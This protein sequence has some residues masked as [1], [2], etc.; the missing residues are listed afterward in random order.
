MRRCPNHRY[1]LGYD[2]NG[3]WCLDGALGTLPR[4]RR[5]RLPE[6]AIIR[7]FG[8]R[9]LVSDPN[10]RRPTFPG[11]RR[12]GS[13]CGRCAGAGVWHRRWGRSAPVGEAF[14]RAMRPW[15]LLRAVAIRAMRLSAAGWLAARSGLSGWIPRYHGDGSNKSG[16]A[17]VALIRNP[18]RLPH[19][20]W[21]A[22][23]SPRLMRCITVWRDMPRRR[24]ASIIGR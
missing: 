12:R 17:F 21:T 22:C 24:V 19:R 10:G 15:R 18:L 5:H 6:A 2:T 1:S 11:E 8:F 23:S 4:C 13:A 14:A 16:V 7:V 3:S 20:T 9:I